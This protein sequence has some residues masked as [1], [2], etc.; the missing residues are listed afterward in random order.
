MIDCL[1]VVGF[2]KIMWFS[3]AVD[4]LHVPV[5]FLIMARFGCAIRIWTWSHKHKET[6]FYAS[7]RRL[8]FVV[9]CMSF[10]KVF[11]GKMWSLLVKCE[12]DLS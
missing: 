5:R 7:S 3:G 8:G 10:C 11:A 12:F 9:A 6:R 2:L 4:A 1:D